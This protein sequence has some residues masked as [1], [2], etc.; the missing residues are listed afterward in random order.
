MSKSFNISIIPNLFTL[1]NL[2]LGILALILTM[3]NQF[4]LAAFLILIS[5]VLDAM[6]GKVARRLDATTSFG[7][8]LD[9][10][11]DLVSFGVAPAILLY[12]SV[13][14]GGFGVFGLAVAVSFA[15]CGAI[16]LARF[17][18]LNI[19][20]YFIGVP[21]TFAGG[22]VALIIAT[23]IALPTWFYLVLTA[24]LAYLMISNFR[25]P[26]F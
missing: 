26:K 24:V 15:L 10:L 11:S 19:T 7:K 25:V 2:L 23:G 1:S 12:A 20:D 3:D 22:V 18:T 17:N 9:S 4:R 13:L 21:I 16:R 14:Q 5:V 8:E 6:D